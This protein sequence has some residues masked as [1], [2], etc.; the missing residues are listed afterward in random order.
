MRGCGEQVHYLGDPGRG[1]VWEETIINCPRHIQLLAMS[2]TIANADQLGAWISRVRPLL[3]NSGCMQAPSSCGASSISFLTTTK[4]MLGAT[5]AHAASCVEQ[6][7]GS[8][9][10]I[11]TDW[12]PV[13]LEWKFCYR[14]PTPGPFPFI[15][16]TSNST[17]TSAVAHSRRLLLCHVPPG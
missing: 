6:V 2:A 5:V 4:G 1:S 12:R 11:T 13:P 3:M 15:F 8:C 16:V 9:K 10:T 17:Q 7:H 14:C